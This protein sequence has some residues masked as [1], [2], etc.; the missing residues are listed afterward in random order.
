MKLKHLLTLVTA[1]SIAVPAF[2][3]AEDDTP[4]GKEMDKISKAL[5]AVNR[6]IENAGQK[7]ANL[8][9]IAAAKAACDAAVKYDPV[10][11]KDIPTAGKE[12]FLIDFQASMSELGKHL[13]ALKAA[14]EAGKTADAKAIYEKIMAQKKDGH[15]KFKAD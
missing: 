15:N 3:R 14:V 6:N 4:M 11:T 13:D 9:N 5:K 1:C 2:T 12:K 7:A 8:E 10:K